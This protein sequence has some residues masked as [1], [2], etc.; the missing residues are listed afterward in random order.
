MTKLERLLLD[1]SREDLVE[2]VRLALGAMIPGN[3][4]L[5]TNWPGFEV[6]AQK[7]VEVVER[8]LG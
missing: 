8:E 6:L 1:K 3:M 2:Q 7:V 5:I 4:T